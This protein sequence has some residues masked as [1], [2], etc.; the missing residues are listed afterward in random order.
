MQ[1][2]HR[3]PTLFNLSMVDVLCCALGC[4][5][6]L[7]LVYFKE[8][9][10][11]AN[12]AG[13]STKE[14]AAAKIRLTGISAELTSTKQ[15]LLA[16]KQQ[17]DYLNA[18]LLQA[19]D[20]QDQWKTKATKAS[21]AYQAV[22]L[23]LQLA[24]AQAANLKIDLNNLRALDA[25]VAETLKKKSQDFMVLA[26]QLVV[27]ASTIRDLEKQLGDQMGQLAG[28]SGKASELQAAL[29]IAEQKT[30]KLEKQLA[31][32]KLTSKE[33][34]EQLALAEA[35]A[36]VLK[37]DLEKRRLELV[38]SNKRYDD[39]YALKKLL[40]QNLALTKSDLAAAKK[41]LAAAKNDLEL[42]NKYL[43]SSKGDLA[44]TGKEL[45]AAK[46]DLAATNKEL[47]VAK[48][49]LAAMSKEL[50]AAQDDL[51]VKMKELAVAKNDLTAKIK[52]L[53]GAKLAT[54]G[55]VGDNKFLSQRIRDLEMQAEKRFA[56]IELTGKKIVFL[57]DMSG[58]MR[59]KDALT[60]DPDKWPL[61]CE[62]FG[63][64]MQSL[65]DLEEFQV[66]MFSDD[67]R[68]PL[69]GKG[70]WLPYKG[71][72][73]VKK[74]VAALKSN[75]PEGGT[76]MALAFEEVFKYRAKGMDTIY[77]I[78]DGL[79]NQG[80]GLPA[81]SAQLTEEQRGFYHGKYIRDKLKST[82]NHPQ[83][84]KQNRVRINAVGFYFDSPDVGAFLWTLAR[85]NDGGF[86]GMSKP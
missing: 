49:D 70:T 52:E 36:T 50:K 4:I 62:I 43:A 1:S 85:E 30:L 55:L 14:L 3:I 21:A 42:V 11:K 61:I 7:W 44:T 39:L 54:A 81:N 65:P 17:H 22:L 24:K 63:K 28:A 15:S 71:S 74:V 37:L 60:E 58:S 86:V 78:S 6:L 75:L 79:P 10:E 67:L 12:A 18:Q 20:V 9:K 23:D 40:E 38:D 26:G 25:A 84:A 51:A 41:D 13:N 5:I 59:S 82:W 29:K 19:L 69:G 33:T 47:A 53:T 46:T 80:P 35:R 34:D 72:E 57:V 16:G 56:G 73:T 76:N 8:A 2:R 48:N 45:I 83:G 32:M 31:A 77:F 68:Y 27:A 66:I 64:L